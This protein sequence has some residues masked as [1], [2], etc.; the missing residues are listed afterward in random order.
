MSN[1]TELLDGFSART[2]GLLRETWKFTISLNN[3]VTY[4]P[5][6][7][8]QKGLDSIPFSRAMFRLEEELKSLAKSIIE[9]QDSPGIP[10]LERLYEKV[11]PAF[12]VLFREADHRQQ[13]VDS[14]SLYLEQQ[15]VLIFT[16]AARTSPSVRSCYQDIFLRQLA[17]HTF[18]THPFLTKESLDRASPE[19]T[20]YAKDFLQSLQRMYLTD[21]EGI[22]RNYHGLLVHLH[23]VLSRESIR[24]PTYAGVP[25]RRIACTGADVVSNFIGEMREMTYLEES[26]R[27]QILT[28]RDASGTAEQIL[29]RKLASSSDWG[30]ELDQ[31]VK[32]MQQRNEDPLKQYNVF[33]AGQQG[34]LQ[35]VEIEEAKSDQVVGQEKNVARLRTLL[36]AFVKGRH[37]P[38]TLLEGE[39]GVGKTLSLQALVHEIEG[40]KLI[41]IPSDY[42]GQIREYAQRMSEEPWR[43]VLYIDDM[44]FDPSHYESFKIGTQGMKRF[45]DN[46]TVV[47]AA[48]PSSLTH[49][50]PEVL[51]RWPIRLKYE[52][53]NL[54][55]DAIL[56]KV[57]KANCRRVK[58]AYHAS[59][60]TE[61]RKQHKAELKDLAP[62][63]VYDFLREVNLTE[64]YGGEK[65][66]ALG[67]ASR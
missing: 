19:I 59:L 18:L 38:F 47:A 35:P 11:E 33:E 55:D 64:D 14:I 31:V 42:L 1:L 61:F 10:A 39:G 6:A 28:L 62:S 17:G 26:Q 53:P 43:T 3:I 41:L 27:A 48:N 49:L 8:D 30:K 21:I 29:F 12:R 34:D 7:W 13:A 16:Y 52:R 54:A 22:F 23:E 24:V 45:Y 56:R 46:V 51:R 66:N 50:P 5:V 9:V 2:N 32:F 15:Q 25:P 20:A 44:T 58:M 37:M 65:L 67:A 60:M 4:S 40:L 63:A 36:T 57:F